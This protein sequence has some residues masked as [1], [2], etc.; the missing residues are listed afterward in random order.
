MVDDDVS[1]TSHTQLMQ[2]LQQVLERLLELQL[3]MSL[4]TVYFVEVLLL[5][6]NSGLKRLRP[7]VQ[8]VILKCRHGASHGL[9]TPPLLHLHLS[10]LEEPDHTFAL[11]VFSNMF[12]HVVTYSLHEE[13]HTS[14][15]HLPQPLQSF[16]S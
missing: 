7:P 10:I 14:P 6:T 16:Q 2:L 13:P 5:C 4:C 8:K 9:T 15:S 3:H 11:L 12:H 1:H